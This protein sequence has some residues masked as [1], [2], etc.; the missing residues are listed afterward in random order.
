MAYFVKGA[1][2]RY[3]GAVNVEDCKTSADVMQKAGLA[4]DVAKCELIAKWDGDFAISGIRFTKLTVYETKIFSP[5][6]YHYLF[7]GNNIYRMLDV[8]SKLAYIHIDYV[9]IPV[10]VEKVKV[11]FGGLQLCDIDYGWLSGM[12]IKD[13]V[14]IK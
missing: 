1:P 7:T 2:F 6:Y 10:D 11:E 3:K 4:W 14:T 9:Y 12:I 5:E 8:S 13:T